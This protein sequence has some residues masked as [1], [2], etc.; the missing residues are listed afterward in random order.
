MEK[1]I[2]ASRRNSFRQNNAGGQARLKSRA[3]F[4]VL[5][6]I[7]PLMG[8]CIFSSGISYPADKV[9]Q[10]IERIAQEEYKL[11][12]T[13]RVVGKT[14]GAL[15]YVDELIDEK[16]QIPKDVHEKMGRIVQVVTRV[17]LST[18][19][20]L[21]FVSVVIRDR[22]NNNELTITRSVDD[23][24]RANAEVFGVDE[25][26][27]RTLFD[28]SKYT[29]DPLG[30]KQFVMKEVRLENF[31]AAQVVQRIRYGFARETVDAKKKGKKSA[32][33]EDAFNPA[34]ILIDGVFEDFQGQK[35]YRFSILSMRS[36]DPKETMLNVF[37][38]VNDV[39]AGYHFTGFDNIEIQ[40]YLNRQKLVLDRETLL[41]YQ[42]Q[43]IKDADIIARFLQE[44]QSV[45][46]AFK[47][48]GFNGTVPEQTAAAQEAQPAAAPSP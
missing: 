14:V 16:G 42:K 43:K 13:A 17:A 8:G 26:I 4:F 22:K 45:Q 12:V 1:P 24:R 46:E 30:E 37:K 10:S 41:A 40:D 21:D 44:S 38:T 11:D 2:P 23:T 35:T 3:L 32:E 25:S 34:F 15:L 39:L 29:P 47:L 18:D 19:L 33:E 9:P 36:E 20:A 5:A 27:N 31:L 28:Q 6:A 7:A 48:F